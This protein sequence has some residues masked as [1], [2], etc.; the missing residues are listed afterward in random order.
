MLYWFTIER[1]ILTSYKKG[2]FFLISG[3][4]SNFTHIIV[5]IISSPYTFETNFS[6]SIPIPISLY[7]RQNID[8]NIKHI[9]LKNLS[10]S[11][12]FE[13]SLQVSNKVNNP[14]NFSNLI[15]TIP[16]HRSMYSI[17]DWEL[18]L[19]ECNRVRR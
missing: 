11:L 8:P 2:Q 5:S 3:F 10:K 15:D 13:T 19:P 12:F 18:T 7:I 4:T 6:Q 1:K 17:A 14:S 16:E 9:I